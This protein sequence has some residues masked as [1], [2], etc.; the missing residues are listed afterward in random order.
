MYRSILVPVDDSEQ[1]YG[2]LDVA[3]LLASASGATVTLFHVQRPTEK[4]VTDMIT[5]DQ[6]MQQGQLEKQREIFNNCRQILSKYGVRADENGKINPNVASAILEEC[7]AGKY[8][9]IVMGH[10]GRTELKQLLL[11]SVA[12]GVLV[13]AKCTTIMVHIPGAEPG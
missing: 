10:R 6:L 9:A 3:G 8:D 4:V 12:N 1:S 13:E 11:G 5:P 2:A 7:N